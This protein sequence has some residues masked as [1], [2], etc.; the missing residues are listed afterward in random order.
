MNKFMKLSAIACAA[1]SA[2]CSLFLEDDGAYPSEVDEG[3]VSIF[4]GNDLTGW[5]GSTSYGV[6]TNEPGVL[7]CFPGQG[8]GGNLLTEKEY[9]NFILRFEFMMPENGNNGLGIR[10]PSPDVD[11][12]Y[13]GMCELQLLDDGGSQYYDAEAKK[14]KLKPYQY[15]GSVYGVVP[16]KRDNIDKQIDW[17]VRNFAAGGSYL[18]V[19]GMW[20]RSEERR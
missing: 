15:T 7:Q 13:Y 4:N 3:F 14:D 12:A 18:R 17:K 9:E 8:S 5:Y 16:V 2:G 10:T 6:S 19:P 20:N 1:V 11:A